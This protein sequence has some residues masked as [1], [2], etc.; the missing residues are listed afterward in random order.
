MKLTA[1]TVKAKPLQD[2]QWPDEAAGCDVE[3]AFYG[4]NKKKTV[5]VKSDKSKVKCYRCK[6]IGHYASECKK[7]PEVTREA[8]RSKKKID[9]HSAF[10]VSNGGKLFK[11]DWIFDSGSSS[12]MCRNL[13]ELENPQNLTDSVKVANNMEMSVVARGNLK[14]ETDIGGESSV[15]K[16]S[17]VLC[18]PELA[19]NLVR[20]TLEGAAR[21]VAISMLDLPRA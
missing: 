9:I 17:D 16:V 4:Q 20:L 1:D 6:Q 13:E 3:R 21:K 14:L 18:I 12:H 2:C 7:E 8:Q 19:M 5:N 10:T 15:I 11:K